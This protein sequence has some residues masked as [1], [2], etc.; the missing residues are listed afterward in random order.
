MS[1]YSLGGEQVFWINRRPEPTR[2]QKLL[3]KIGLWRR[4]ETDFMS[5][6]L[7]TDIDQLHDE[8]LRVALAEQQKLRAEG[9]SFAAVPVIN[10]DGTL[11]H[12]LLLPRGRSRRSAP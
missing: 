3:G 9:G 11:D 10:T 7:V 2:G 5:S 6:I 8:R 1:E 12:V 4:P